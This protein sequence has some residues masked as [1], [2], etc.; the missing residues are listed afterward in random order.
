MPILATMDK[1]GSYCLTEPGAGSR[2]CFIWPLLGR[3]QVHSQ[4]IKGVYQW[5]RGNWCIFVMCRTGGGAKGSSTCVIV[6]K[7][8]KGLHSARRRRRWAGTLNP[9]GRSFED[10]EVPVENLL[11]SRGQGFNINSPWVTQRRQN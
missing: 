10:C 5:S 4:R 7:G 2:C 9:P 6:E 3:E 8:M 1:L 11:G